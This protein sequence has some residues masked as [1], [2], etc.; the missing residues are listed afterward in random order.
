MIRTRM[1]CAAAMAA[2]LAAPAFA[3]ELE[4]PGQMAWTAYDTGSAGYNQSV[5]IGAAMQNATGANLRVL[6]G[7]ND[8][9]RME[10][11]R[12]GRV[13]ISMMGVGT[14]MVQ[15]G[16]FE[17]GEERWGPQKVRLILLNN[18]GD[19]ALAVGVATDAGVEKYED[20]KGKRVAYVKGAPALNVNMEA[21]LAYAGLGWDD[22]EKV[23]FGG[24]GDS[25]NGVINGQVDAAY[26]IMTAGQAFQAEAGPRGLMWPPID[27]ANE[28]GIARMQEV[29]PYFNPCNSVNGAV[30][31]AIEGGVPSACYPY[32]VLIT[33]DTAD[34]DLIYNVTKAM[35]VLYP[36]YENDAP[37]VNGWAMKFQDFT[38]VVPYHEGAVRYFEEIGVWTEEAE[39]HNQKLIERQ[40]VLVEAWEELKAES[41]ENWT[42]AWDEKRRAALKDAGM[43]VVF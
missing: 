6:P 11:L 31:T 3:Q 19:T 18:S 30:V 20:L 5:A 39:T 42:E 25:W 7:K 23:E 36:E 22:V 4:L 26:A 29:A 37:G 24:Y 34:A 12:Q 38:W 9:A 17:F 41:P 21:Y 33:Y 16:V 14:Y 28:E 35:D 32:P 27:P 13:P 1:L 10:P 15:E 40:E 8:V 43:Q 2:V